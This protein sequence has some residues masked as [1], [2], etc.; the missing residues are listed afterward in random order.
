MKFKNKKTGE[1][2]SCS[3]VLLNAAKLSA[4][5]RKRLFWVGKLVSNNEFNHSWYE[6]VKIDQPQDK[7]ILLKDILENDVDEKYYVKGVEVK[8]QGKEVG[9]ELDKAHSLM[10]R[11]YKGFGNQAM[12]GVQRVGFLNQGG[13]GDRIY[14]P[15]G[16]SVTLSANGGGR[17]YKTG[18]YAVTLT[19]TRTEEGK[20]KRRE[21]RNKTGKDW[22]S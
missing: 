4:Q 17:G 11:D 18:L 8:K 20:R 15:E 6:Q 9:K 1:I 14:S 22:G 21:I 10:A 3:P 2:I 19:K 16:K 13:Q 12:T 5:N 7:G